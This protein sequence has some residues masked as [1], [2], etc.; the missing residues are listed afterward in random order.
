[1]SRFVLSQI[2]VSLSRLSVILGISFF[3][4]SMSP[5]QPNALELPPFSLP[6]SSSLRPVGV[7]EGPPIWWC[8]LWNVDDAGVRRGVEGQRE[9]EKDME[10]RIVE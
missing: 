10:E 7:W 9:G 5:T 1:M 4:L 2:H 3:F 6:L 8:H